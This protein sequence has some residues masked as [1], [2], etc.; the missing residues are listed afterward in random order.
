MSVTYLTNSLVTAA[1]RTARGALV[2]IFGNAKKSGG[3]Q[4]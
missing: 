2:H 1:L 4:K 3:D